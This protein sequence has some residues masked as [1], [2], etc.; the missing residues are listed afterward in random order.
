MTDQQRLD[1][2][3]VQLNGLTPVNHH[4]FTLK[5]KQLMKPSNTSYDRSIDRVILIYSYIQQH[6]EY[7]SELFQH[8]DRLNRCVKDATIRLMNQLT[9]L[10]ENPNRN[11]V[12]HPLYLRQIAMELLL[13]VINLIDTNMDL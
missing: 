10:N 3:Q 11:E 2:I 12:K 13:H 8:H 4:D 1:Q 7:A 6:I 5:L 9:N